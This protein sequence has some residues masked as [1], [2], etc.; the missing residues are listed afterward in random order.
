MIAQSL[1]LNITVGLAGHA[2]IPITRL[3][4]LPAVSFALAAASSQA[5]RAGHVWWIGL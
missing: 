4:G 3:R 2:R 1:P 5:F